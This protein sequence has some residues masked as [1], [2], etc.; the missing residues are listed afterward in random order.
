MVSVY[1]PETVGPKRPVTREPQPAGVLPHKM[2]ACLS[3]F[4]E[5]RLILSTS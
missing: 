4:K 3:I 2:M 1:R 5:G